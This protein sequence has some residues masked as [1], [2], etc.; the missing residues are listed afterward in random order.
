MVVSI[1]KLNMSTN[2]MKIFDIHFI[3][4]V[5]MCTCVHIYLITDLF[6]YKKKVLA[7]IWYNTLTSKPVIFVASWQ[8]F[9]DFPFLYVLYY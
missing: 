7:N 8:Q 5:I 4:F 3:V 1:S 2:I 6:I 9:T